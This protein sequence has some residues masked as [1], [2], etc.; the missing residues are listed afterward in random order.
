MPWAC[1]KRSFETLESWELSTRCTTATLIDYGQSFVI[2]TASEIARSGLRKR[3][4]L[5]HHH[6]YNSKPPHLY[7]IGFLDKYILQPNRQPRWTNK[8]YRWSGII[9][10]S[11]LREES[12]FWE[13]CCVQSFHKDTRDT[14]TALWPS[15]LVVVEQ[16][17]LTQKAKEAIPLHARNQYRQPGRS[18]FFW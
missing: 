11:W 18:F 10:R 2:G 14:N 4:S 1:R 15:R 7:K 5:K 6:K 8:V 12:N 3:V 16:P 13:L 9:Y 17:L